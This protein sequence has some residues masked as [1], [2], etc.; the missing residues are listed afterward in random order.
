MAFDLYD[1]TG[2]PYA[3][4]E[5][6]GTLYTF[7]GIPIAY[8]S[9][10]SVY[11]F[12]GRHIGY[13]A[14]GLLRDGHGNVLL[15]TDRASDG[16]MKPMKHMRPMKGMKRMLPMKGRKQTKP[17]RPMNTLS[18]SQHSPEALFETS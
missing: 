1:S 17:M 12:S 9:D 11:A 14:G 3:Y 10:D 16:P 5:D 18:W 13:F 15:F 8:F 2:R 7:T 6:E 4:C